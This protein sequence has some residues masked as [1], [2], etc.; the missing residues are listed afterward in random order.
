MKIGAD[1]IESF[2]KQ[3]KEDDVILTNKKELRE[4]M[5]DLALDLLIEYGHINTAFQTGQTKPAN[6]TNPK[7]DRLLRQ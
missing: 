7:K 2:L 6:K 5:K 3:F 4:F 1:T